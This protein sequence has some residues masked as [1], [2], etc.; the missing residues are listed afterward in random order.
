MLEKDLDNN[1]ELNGE[2]SGY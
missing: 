1:N 2:A